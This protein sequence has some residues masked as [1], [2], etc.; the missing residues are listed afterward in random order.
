M[1]SYISDFNFFEIKNMKREYLENKLTILGYEHPKD[2]D[3]VLKDDLGYHVLGRIGSDLEH[4]ENPL[5]LWMVKPSK[6]KDEKIEE[7]KKEIQEDKLFIQNQDDFLSRVR[8]IHPDFALH[9]REKISGD[10][11][12]T[13]SK[14]VSKTGKLLCDLCLKSLGSIPKMDMQDV[15]SEWI[16]SQEFA[17]ACKIE[18]TFMTSEYEA[19]KKEADSLGYNDESVKNS[20][21]CVALAQLVRDTETLSRKKQKY[22]TNYEK[23]NK[24][25]SGLGDSIKIKTVDKKPEEGVERDD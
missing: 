24:F 20:S 6:E 25:L 23:Y 10:D 18:D 9:M 4:F 15:I 7:F 22:I 19:F 5:Q 2:V 8:S 16:D 3:E 12:K 21:V 14:A 11:W 13:Y 17:K 1:N